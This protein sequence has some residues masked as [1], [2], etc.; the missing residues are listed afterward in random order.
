[1]GRGASCGVRT[2]EGDTEWLTG[3]TPPKVPKSCWCHASTVLAHLIK[4][5]FRLA[6]GT[7]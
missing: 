7:D 3:R 2:G 5:V 1:M 4:S 6:I